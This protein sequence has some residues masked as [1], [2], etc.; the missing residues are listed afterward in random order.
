M[1][2]KWPLGALQV[3][4]VPEDI[5]PPIGL[6]TADIKEDP[7]GST[8]HACADLEASMSDKWPLGA[9]QVAFVPEEIAPPSGLHTAA[10][11]AI[12]STKHL[13]KP[14][15]LE[16][17]SLLIWQNPT[18]SLIYTTVSA[19]QRAAHCSWAGHPVYQAP[20]QATGTGAGEHIASVKIICSLL[21]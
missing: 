16:Q 2:D 10:G 21:A 6:H 8:I 1:S 7:L 13:V 11:L 9:L 17:V 20:C 5:A 19:S 15:A 4:F 14:Q 3:V 12:L 18:S